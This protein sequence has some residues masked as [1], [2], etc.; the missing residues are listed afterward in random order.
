[1]AGRLVGVSV[2]LLAS[3][4]VADS[5]TA[6]VTSG[7]TSTDSAEVTC[8]ES[9]IVA[10]SLGLVSFAAGGLFFFS[11]WL[12][13]GPGVPRRLA[14]KF[15][16]SDFIDGS[17]LNVGECLT[18]DFRPLPYLARGG[19]RPSGWASERG[20]NQ[21]RVRRQNVSSK[22]F[23]TLKFIMANRLKRRISCHLVVAAA[24]NSPPQS[25]S[26]LPLFSPTYISATEFSPKGRHSIRS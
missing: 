10:G 2:V 23:A 12:F 26:S 6:S 4:V 14:R 21:D 25:S 24:V 17:Q 5:D 13:A 3:V 15:Q 9:A 20:G 16:W 7:G 18:C 19:A 11:S 8:S 1:M 22:C